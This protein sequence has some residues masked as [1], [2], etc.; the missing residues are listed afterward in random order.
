MRGR[1]NLLG[2]TRPELEAFFSGLGE[3]SYR[4]TQVLKWIHQH[5]VTDF[6]SMTNLSKDLRVTL[7]EV[8][9]I[10][11]PAVVR[12]ETS[13]DGTHKWL[14]GLDSANCIETVFIPENDRGTLCVSSQ[15]GCALNCRFCATAQQGFNRNLTSAEIVGQ[16]WLAT[17][18]LGVDE[19]RAVTNVVMMG[20]GEPLLNFDNVTDAMDLMMEDCAYGIARRR[21]T[22]STAGIVPGI[23]RLKTRCPVSLAVSLHAPDDGLRDELVPVNRSYPIRELL[24]ACRDYVA[25]APKT[26]ITFE[27]VMLD[28]VNDSPE[29]ARAL[30]RLLRDMPAKV[31]LIPFN[32][33]PDTHYR[34]SPLPV[35]DT[36][37]DLLMKAGLLAITRK[38]RGDDIDA[39]CGQLAGRVQPR[40][41]RMARRRGLAPSDRR[42]TDLVPVQ[43]RKTLT[44]HIHGGSSY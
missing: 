39:A 4:A 29:H 35:I 7:A 27:Y 22:L 30:G 41:Q 17:Q 19:R 28:G 33:F 13:R 12:H 6:S 42:A 24:A 5:H 37:R 23:L 3:R 34:R 14:F 1:L 10:R 31:N 32:P 43:D 25:S 2:M 38:T 21:V 36:F 15:V 20:M 8:S 26:N 40:S 18:L 44:N 9:E 11:A 16:L